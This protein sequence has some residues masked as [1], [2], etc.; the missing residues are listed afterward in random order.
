MGRQTLSLQHLP[1][2]FELLTKQLLTLATSCVIVFLAFTRAEKGAPPLSAASLSSLSAVQPPQS[3]PSAF[4]S[5][6]GARPIPVGALVPVLLF[7]DRCPLNFPDQRSRPGR[8]P[9]KVT[10]H[11]SFKS[12][13]CNT[14]GPPRKCC[15]QKTYG[16]SKPFRCNTYKKH[17]G[18]AVRER[19]LHS[20]PSPIFRT[21]F[22]VPYPATPLFATLTKTPGCGGMLPILECAI[23]YFTTVAVPPGHCSTVPGA[24]ASL[25]A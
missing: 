25:R 8:D 7:A 3:S 4:T 11:H 21:L 18:G 1:R 10:A 2:S 16:L 23:R 15:K 13:S 22:Q 14:Y 9:V 24:E 5:V 19:F 20:T 12:F 17:G 6:S